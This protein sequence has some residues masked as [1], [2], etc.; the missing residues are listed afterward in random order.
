VR[1]GAQSPDTQCHWLLRDITARK[2]AEAAL[3]AAN[4][5]RQRLEREAQRAEH[6][7][8][9][10]R[11]AAGLSH[12]IRN[13]LGAITLHTELLEEEWHDPSPDHREVIAQS[14]TEIKTELA[15]LDDLLQ[16]YLT[17]VRVTTIER[18]PQDLGQAVQT[19]AAEMHRQA[20]ACG[21]SIHSEDLKELQG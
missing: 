1:R 14:L 15:R 8:L 10:G 3:D 21:V 13:P 17:L 11:L 18:T 12:E 2:E 20:M 16:D 19:W 9:L 5:E 4:A 6:F 7:A